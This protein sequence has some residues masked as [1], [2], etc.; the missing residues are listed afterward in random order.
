MP[1]GQLYINNIDAYER[2]GISM[3]NNALSVLM[4]PPSKKEWITNEVRDEDGT[5]YLT[6]AYA[7]KKA[8]RDVTININLTAPNEQEFYRRYEL[9]CNEVLESGIVNIRTSFQPNVVYRCKYESCTQFTQFRREMAL[10]SLKLTENN[11][12]D[13]SL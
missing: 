10:F 3:D 8:S 2:Y 13:R 12:A 6:G 5:R 4:T 9:F 1:K 11:P 7:P